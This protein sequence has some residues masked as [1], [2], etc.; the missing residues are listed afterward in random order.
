MCRAGAG[1]ISFSSVTSS[2]SSDGPMINP[3]E[4]PAY[5]GSNTTIGML[6]RKAAK[7]DPTTRVKA[8]QELCQL[9]SF[10]A[11]SGPTPE[12]I[13][14]VRG[15]VSHF[16]YLYL[17]MCFDSERQVRTALNALLKQVVCL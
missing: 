2:V 9:H 3:H 1:L 15:L 14:D 17:R 8:M 6:F 5:G 7:R 10:P 16:V 13:A 4:S 12:Q 11:E